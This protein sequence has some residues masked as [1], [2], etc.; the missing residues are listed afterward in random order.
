ME[1]LELL[2]GT[3]RGTGHEEYPTVDDAEYEEEMHFVADKSFLA[4]T[5]R[6][7]R[8]ADGMTL[9]RESGFWRAGDDGALEVCLGH[10]L[11]LVEVAEG[12]IDGSTILLHS[13]L[14]GR[15]STGESVAGVERCYE[16]EDDTL[17]YDIW[18]ALDRVPMTQH[19]EATLHR[20]S[21]A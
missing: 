18:M 8:A 11:G 16:L 19:L 17:R 14:V 6:A 20:Q 7:W 4:Y 3:W 12:R 5:Q 10:P 1:A 9:H 2:V 15:T 13:T 21:P